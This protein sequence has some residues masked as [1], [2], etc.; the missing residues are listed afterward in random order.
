MRKAGILYRIIF[1]FIAGLF[2]LTYVNQ[3]LFTH[4]HVLPDGTVVLH[5]HPYH[6]EKSHDKKIPVHS[7][8]HT[9]AE[10]QALSIHIALISAFVFLILLVQR[11]VSGTILSLNTLSFAKDTPFCI[12]ARAPPAV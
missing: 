10:Y 7:H 2:L 4:T 12:T 5:A 8:S 9:P 6:K 3:A 1:L 11:P